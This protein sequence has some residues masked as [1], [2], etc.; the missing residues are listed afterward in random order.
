LATAY[1]KAHNGAEMQASLA[2]TLY[3]LANNT[4]D[5]YFRM[6]ET[7]FPPHF[8]G[9]AT[10]ND[11][12]S[13]NLEPHAEPIRWVKEF[14]LVDEKDLTAIMDAYDKYSFEAVRL[15]RG[16]SGVSAIT[17]LPPRPGEAPQTAYS[18]QHYPLG[19]FD[20]FLI[21]QKG[22]LMDGTF[23]IETSANFSALFRKTFTLV[24]Y[25]H[26]QSGADMLM[27]STLDAAF[28]EKHPGETSTQL[29]QKHFFPLARNHWD[30]RYRLIETSFAPGESKKP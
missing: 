8:T 30:I 5:T 11:A 17:S 10:G 19:G 7:G 21:P 6:I 14:F 22:V 9:K 15:M 26:Q 3:P 27:S 29:L 25:Q 28:A 23:P 20:E 16:D 1:A 2:K 24:T 18:K 13:L 4:W 12:D